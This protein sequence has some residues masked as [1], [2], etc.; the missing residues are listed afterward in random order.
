MENTEK[1]YYE[2]LNIER[3]ASSE[4]V[5]EAYREL[6]RIYHPDSN[7]YDEIIDTDLDPES[8]GKFKEITAAYNTLVH[9]EKRRE[10]DL[11][12]PGENL[13]GWDSPGEEP[14]VTSTGSFRTTPS[15]FGTFGHIR[16]NAKRAQQVEEVETMADIIGRKRSLYR[17]LLSV[18][19]L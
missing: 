9:P 12:L 18:F 1:T 15:A 10:Y 7:F 19:G 5:R 6:A 2:M 4:E 8:L 17:R 11:S 3:N 13:Q 16:T 14:S